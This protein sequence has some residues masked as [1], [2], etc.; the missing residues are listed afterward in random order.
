MRYLVDVLLAI[1]EIRRAKLRFSLLAGAIGLLVFLILFQQLLLGSLLQSFTGAIENQS[2]PVLVFGAEARRNVEGSIIPPGKEPAV[3]AIEGVGR[4][5]PIGEGTFTMEAGGQQ[6]DVAV[7]G[8]VPGG[9]G[10]PTKV[11]SGRLPQGPG[12]AVASGE[13]K[14]KGFAIG[15]TVTS[16]AGGVPVTI[17]GLTEGSRFSVAPTLFTPYATYEQLRKAANP[18]ATAVLPTLLGVDPAAGT[19]AATLAARITE[20]VPGVE[21][22]D[23]ASAVSKAPAVASIQ[24]SFAIILLLA[25]IVVTLVVGFF[26]LI[27]T[28]QKASSLTLLRAVGAPSGYLVRSLLVQI[29]LV[30][31]GGLVVGIA[32]LLG[33]AAGA[34]AGLPLE[35]QPALVAGTSVTVIVFAV[36]ASSVSIVRVLRLD[37]FSV[38]GRQSLGGTG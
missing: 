17:V 36:L 19:D 14:A 25:F 35:V 15:D 11:V 24:Q 31:G 33:A 34:R 5:A 2:A 10:Q 4:V 16:A 28:V 26:F 22:L 6:V 18:T 13:D 32:L 30:V 23:R 12:E 3:Q 1:G 29:G 9:P 8:Y 27:L 20:Q 7:I 37:P 38:V 21:A